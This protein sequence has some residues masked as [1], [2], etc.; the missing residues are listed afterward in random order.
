LS[1][2]KCIKSILSIK[3]ITNVSAYRISGSNKPLTDPVITA[4]KGHLGHGVAAACAMESV[5]ALKSIYEQ[6]I[7]QIRN[8]NEPVDPDLYFAN[9]NINT[10]IKTVVKNSLVFGGINYSFVFKKFIV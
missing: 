7:P 9:Q 5:L 10:E 3:D 8:L 1:E 2:A 4:N 6:T